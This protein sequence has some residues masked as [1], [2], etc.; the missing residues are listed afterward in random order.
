MSFAVTPSVLDRH[1]KKAE[2]DRASRLLKNAQI[3]G[4][5]QVQGSRCRVH[6]KIE[7][8]ESLNRESSKTVHRVPSIMYLATIRPVK[9]ATPSRRART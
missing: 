9:S 7:K 8:E 2:K 3:Q 4:A 1:G 6:G 5:L